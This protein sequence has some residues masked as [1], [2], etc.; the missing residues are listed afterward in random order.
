MSED[1]V[2]PGDARLR[3]AECG[4]ITGASFILDEEREILCPRC[5]SP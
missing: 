1:I 3:C 5:A 4:D 2:L